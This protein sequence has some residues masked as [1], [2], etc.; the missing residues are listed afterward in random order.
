MDNQGNHVFV[1][2]LQLAWEGESLEAASEKIQA[3]IECARD[4]G[5]WM[6]D[7][8]TARARERDPVEFISYGGERPYRNHLAQGTGQPMTDRATTAR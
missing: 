3:V 7:G 6:T 4:Q 8:H 5:L 1:T 2:D